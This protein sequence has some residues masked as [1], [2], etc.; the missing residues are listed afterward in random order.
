MK[1]TAA[2]LLF[3][4]TFLF[5]VILF[6]DAEDDIAEATQAWASA[7]NS[8][9]VEN[10]LARYHQDAVFWGTG[11]AIIR[12]T[13]TA[14]REYFSGLAN[15]LNAEVEIGDSKVRRIGDIGFNSGIY[16]FK[17][18][19]NG[20]TISRPARFSFAYRLVGNE[21]MIIDHHSSASPGQ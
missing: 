18:M 10:V 19:R 2:I 12:D 3:L 21:W 1:K 8:H 20:E 16:I 13:P 15:R 5:S 9:S 6:A 4:N 7:Y 14:I 11:S 17:D